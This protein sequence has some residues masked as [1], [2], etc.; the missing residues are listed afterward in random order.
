MA[1]RRS[2]STKPLAPTLRTLVKPAIRV[3]RALT[4]PLMASLASVSVTSRIGIEVGIH[5]E[6]GVDVDQSGQE[7]HRPQIDHGI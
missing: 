7:R 5:G 2:T 3:V 1:S 6:V 4:T